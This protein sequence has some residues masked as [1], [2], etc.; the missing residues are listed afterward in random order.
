M[1]SGTF[2]GYWGF[3]RPTVTIRYAAQIM[4]R[5]LTAKR[6]KFCQHFAQ[7]RSGPGAWVHAFDAGKMTARTIEKEASKLLANPDI[8]GRIDELMSAATAASP[9]TMDLAQFF[10]R[11]VLLATADPNELIG[12]KIGNCRHCNGDGFGYQWRE[13]E[14]L[15]ACDLADERKEL[16]PPILGGFGFRRNRPPNPD[17]PECDGEGVER[18]V[19]RDTSKL[20]AAGKVLYKGVKK[21]RN[22]PEIQMHDQTKAT[23]LL[24]RVLGAYKDTLDIKALLGAVV[25]T[26]PLDTDDPHAAERAYRDMM[27]G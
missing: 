10:G 23:E 3:L 18:E 4:A 2:W 9:V 16:A 11:L 7:H 20:S 25:Q 19:P 13:R 26:K 15:E 1:G 6:E 17:C 24:G 21:T 22:G 27:R 5:V 8:A 14:Y 12:L